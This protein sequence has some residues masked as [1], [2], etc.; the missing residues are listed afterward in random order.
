[1]GGTGLSVVTGAFGYTGRYIARRLLDR[2]GRVRTLTGHPDRLDPFGGRVGIAPLSFGDPAMLSKGLEGADVLYNTYW[3]R[4]PRGRVTFERAVENSVSLIRAAQ[5]AGVR[6]IVH[7]SITG[8]SVESP[9]PYFRAKGLVEETL[10]GSGLSYAIVRPTVVFGRED[11]LINNIAWFLRRSPVFTVFGSGDYPV[12]PV[13]V[14]DVAEI[15]VDAAHKDGDLVIDAAGPET[16]TFDE[17]LRLIAA[18]VG[19]RT[20]L[21]HVRPALAYWLSRM[22]GLPLR[23]VVVTRDEIEGLSR[24]L[25]VSGGPPAGR[26]RLSQWL[27]ENAAGVGAR[28]ASEL[29]RHYR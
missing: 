14:E 22:A 2:G 19:A 11:I 28:Y 13:Y 9:L 27:A 29:Q 25:L 4:F 15:A 24:G 26:T 5:E 12:Q 21:V 18:T 20:R 6:R 16:Y 23:D 8:A 10:A 3:V 7:L 1:M 17:L